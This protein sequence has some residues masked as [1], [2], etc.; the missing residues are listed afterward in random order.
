MKFT[1]RDTVTLVG[2]SNEVQV[3]VQGVLTQALVDTGSAVST[4][5]RKFYDTHLSDIPLQPVESLLTLECADGTELPYQGVIAC[6]L[7]IDG[8][9]DTPE[10]IE[11]LFLIVN[12]KSYHRSVPVLIGTN[13]LSVLLTET[14]QKFGVRFLQKAKLH[15]PWYLA[16]RCMTLRERELSRRS[17]VL[18]H[19]RSAE[20]TP[21][22]IP[23]NSRVIIQGYLHN[24]LPYQPVCGMLSPTVNS[25]IPADLD[26]EPSVITYDTARTTP[27]PVHVSNITINTVQVRPHALLCEIQQVKVENFPKSNI[28]EE[29]DIIDQVDFPRDEFTQ[30]QIQ[31]IQRLHSDFDT[32][33]SKGDTDIGYCP[34]VEHRIELDDERPFKQRYRRIPPSMLDEVRDHI[35]QQLSAGIIRRSHSPFSSNVVLVRKKNG[36]LRIC[37]DYRHLNSRTKKDNYALPRID[38]IL[39]SLVGN[40]WFSV[41]DMKSGYYQI[42]I[43]EEHKERTAF[44][45]GPLGFFEHNRM[46][47]GLVNAP[48]TYQRLM[49]ECLGDLLHHTCFIYLDDAIVF[50][51]ESFDE[52]LDR[53]RMVFRRLKDSGIKLSP[54]KCS[55]FKRRVKYVGHIVSANGIEADDDKIQ[56]VKDWPTPTRPEEVRRFLGFVGYYRK[57]IKDFSKI[58]R[59]L[60]NLIP[61]TI[62]SKTT[63]K[64]TTKTPEWEW[65]QEHEE[66]FATL[67]KC[68][69]S[70]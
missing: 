70:L 42:P 41:L 59:P 63:K 62:R 34:F 69:S 8:I 58:A 25:H 51:G 36:Q 9:S 19:V 10:T 14:K 40:T 35:E 11:C 48:A 13:I 5:S 57:F 29:S 65:N 7:Q 60:N 38:E 39:D 18:A 50:S 56:K 20:D 53:L 67:K 16:F 46:A 30:E 37:I 27:I 68:L 22:T 54:G 49:E 1:S 26:I 47:M 6:E 43:A 31:Q 4:I 2:S 17:Y 32:L 21:I 44:T 28:S 3:Q 55:L 12:D 52:H 45:V 33:F 61:S 23:P 64:K 15:T 66:A 24:E